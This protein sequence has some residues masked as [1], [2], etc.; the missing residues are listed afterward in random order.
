MQRERADFHYR[1]A[2]RRKAPPIP[3]RCIPDGG[4][5]LQ[6]KEPNN[7]LEPGGGNVDMHADLTPKSTTPAFEEPQ[8][9]SN[10]STVSGL[11]SAA[12]PA[13]S[14]LS[15]Q[16]ASGDTVLP[17]GIPDL[18]PGEHPP[19][20]P[21]IQN[22]VDDIAS[23]QAA[24]ASPDGGEM[25]NRI[26]GGLFNDNELDGSGS[27]AGAGNH[28][29]E[30]DEAYERETVFNMGL[31]DS[32][33]FVNSSGP[34]GVPI[35]DDGPIIEKDIGS[36]LPPLPSVQFADPDPG[37]EGGSDITGEQDDHQSQNPPA[38]N[39][40]KGKRSRKAAAQKPKA[41]A[42]KKGLRTSEQ[43]TSNQGLSVEGLSEHPGE[44]ENGELVG[45]R[46]RKRCVNSLQSYAE[47]V[48][49]LERQKKRSRTH[50]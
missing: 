12:P 50:K 2:T 9:S 43:P 18:I 6:L 25:N 11:A 35:P 44:I 1:G 40:R 45:K 15:S 23:A 4:V 39:G 20:N 48:E 26:L 36:R 14:E 29:D 5:L 27:D 42:T 47:R 41:N 7:E 49:E 32:T 28:P 24:T 13:S 46:Q 16:D 21:S 34:E 31:L 8:P 30:I 17:P 10:A 19:F 33:N 3:I 38:A 22:L 37:A